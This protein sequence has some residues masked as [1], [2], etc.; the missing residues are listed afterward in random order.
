M[1]TVKTVR[2]GNGQITWSVGLGNRI[3]SVT[4]DPIARKGQL[5]W[6]DIPENVR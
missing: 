1:E 6:Y 5:S 3:P 4:G 2:I